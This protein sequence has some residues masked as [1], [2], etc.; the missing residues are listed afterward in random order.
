M[1]ITKK[2]QMNKLK[3]LAIS[4]GIIYVWFG[5]L[6]FFPNVSAAEI[7]ATKTVETLTLHLIPAKFGYF[8]LAMIEV[9]IG[10]GL[11]IGWKQTI[12]VKIALGHMF[13]TFAP[14]FL[15]PEE[16]FTAAPYGFTI[17]GQYIMKNIV[18]IMAL[19]L[20]LPSKKKLV[21]AENQQ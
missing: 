8:M 5:M 13:F 18:I 6:K 20:L 19:F 9:I 2:H 15:F 3:F 4:I 21:L 16:S 11:I 12:F 1:L 17:V 7:L 14:L 10:L